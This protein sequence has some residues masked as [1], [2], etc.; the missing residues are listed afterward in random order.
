MRR[1]LDSYVIHS[2]N[3]AVITAIGDTWAIENRVFINQANLLENAEDDMVTLV[4]HYY[5]PS[6]PQEC[7]IF[8]KRFESYVS[9]AWWLRNNDMPYIIGEI[10]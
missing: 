3:P 8:R 4:M 9:A 7:F 6:D 10:V 1:K 5:D 2:R